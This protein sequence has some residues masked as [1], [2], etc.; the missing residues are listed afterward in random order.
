MKLISPA[1]FSSITLALLVALCLLSLSSGAV[2]LDIAHVVTAL[3]GQGD[4][5]NVFIL[6]QLRLPRTLNA[7]T[8]GA[9]LGG[10][11]AVLQ[12]LFRNPLA[13][14]GIIGVSAGAALGAGIAIVLL[15]TALFGFQL[16]ITSTFAFIGSLVITL[17]VYRLGQTPYGS[18]MTLM[19]LG[20][21]AIGAIA[22][23]LLGLLQY[24]AD[25][26]ALRDLTTWQLGSLAQSN[27]W[28]VGI[29]VVVLILVLVRFHSL[30]QALN[31]LLLGD[32]EA[33]HLGV[34]IERVKRQC[35]FLTALAIGIAVAVAG[36]IGFVGLV[37]PHICRGLLS[38]NHKILIP[39]SS[40]L[41]AV[42][43]L[44]ADILARAIAPP[45]EVPIGIITAL[46]GAPFF[47]ALLLKLKG[48][49]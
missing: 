42:L 22:F 48:K 15:P 25:D 12:G 17:F 7:I 10:C 23:A 13:D 6:Q 16:G 9:I 32:I 41:G 5:G 30:A 29:T 31:A 43:L 39:A 33:Q 49:V 4:S 37:V 18:Q 11:G 21:I 44:F 24:I 47:I 20:G 38:A 1:L 19:L 27:Y 14:P 46:L 3:L 8:I 36:I 2:K 35:I 28:H 40:L 45:A 34:N 26:R